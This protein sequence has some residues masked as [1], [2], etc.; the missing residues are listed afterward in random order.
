MARKPVV[1]QPRMPVGPQG[2]KG[3]PA[4]NVKIQYSADNSNWH[5]AYQQGDAYIRFSTDGGT[6]WGDGMAI[7]TNADTLDGY[8][9]TDFVLE[10]DYED[11]DVLNKIKNVDGAG[12]GLDADTVDGLHASEI[13]ADKVDGYHASQTPTANT[14]PVAD[15]NG[16][17][18]NWTEPWVANDSRAKVALNADNA[19]PI[20]ACRAW[21][22]FNGTTSPI[23]IRAGGNVSSI[24]D[25]G[26]AYYAVN[27][28]TPMPDSNYSVA[29]LCSILSGND[30]GFV[31]ILGVSTSSVKIHLY[32]DDGSS[33]TGDASVVCVSIFR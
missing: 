13:D 28:A 25:L 32:H 14:I 11:T 23:T 5:D 21:V 19:P 29:G 22:N 20:Y 18:D 6:T 17:I 24:T 3:E 16:K 9:A 1:I 30:T 26:S 31:T 4:P 2:P 27:F 15:A 12:S 7:S 10:T 33:G 8:Q